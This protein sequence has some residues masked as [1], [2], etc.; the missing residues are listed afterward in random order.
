MARL[1]DFVAQDDCQRAIGVS[2]AGRLDSA[3][4]QLARLTRLLTFQLRSFRGVVIGDEAFRA[5][6]DDGGWLRFHSS[7]ASI[8]VENV[9]AGDKSVINWKIT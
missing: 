3:E 9:P 5:E 1:I 8:T 6:P 2:P 7:D 4:T